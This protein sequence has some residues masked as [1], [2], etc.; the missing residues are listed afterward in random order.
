MFNLIQVLIE[1]VSLLQLG[2]SAYLSFR[3]SESRR[4]N[5][6]ACNPEKPVNIY[7]SLLFLHGYILDPTLADDDFGPTYGNRVASEKLLREP[8]QPERDLAKVQ[9]AA[10][11]PAACGCG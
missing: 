2:G 1:K 6:A 4:D 9:P 3:S 8:W 7:K 11:V 5:P 10:V